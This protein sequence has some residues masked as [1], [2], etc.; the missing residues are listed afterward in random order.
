[1]MYFQRPFLTLARSIALRTPGVRYRH[2]LNQ[3]PSRFGGGSRPRSSSRP[4]FSIRIGASRR[5]PRG[6][7]PLGICGTT[8]VGVETGDSKGIMSGVGPSS[9]VSSGLGRGVSLTSGVRLGVGRGVSRGS[10]VALGVARGVS[11]DVGFGVGRG[12]GVGVGATLG[13][14]RGVTVGRGTGRMSSRALRK[15]FFFCSSVSWPRS[16]GG[17]A[18]AHAKKI[19]TRTSLFRISPRTLTDDLASSSRP[20]EVH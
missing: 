3:P 7:R 14:G 11:S 8:R 20:I 16:S 15:S 13:F 6:V 2:L 18:E 19:R 12:V 5:S 10:G 1:M 9:G 4:D 17:C